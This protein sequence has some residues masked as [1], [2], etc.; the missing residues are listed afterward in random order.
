MT[1]PCHWFSE[2]VGL[3]GLTA[4][5]SSD[6][7]LATWM[8]FG[9]N[10]HDLGSFGEETDKITDLHQIHEK[11]FFIERRDGIASIKRCRRDLSSDGVR[12]L[13]TASGRGRLKE[14]LESS[15]FPA[16]VYEDALAFDHEISS[17]PIVHMVHALDFTT[18]TEE[19]REAIRDRLRM[20]HTDAQ[21]HIVF[22]RGLRCRMY[23]RQFIL[24]MG[25]H[26]ADEMDSVGFRVYWA[27]SVRK[28]ADK[29]D[30]SAHWIE[31]SSD[32]DFLSTFPS[33]TSIRDPLRRLCHKL[34]AFSIAGRSQ[35][36]K[37]V[38]STD[39]FCLRSMDVGA[40]NVP[41]LLAQYLLRYASERKRGARMSIGQFV[42]HLAAH[43]R[44]LTDERL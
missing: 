31:I 43:F 8:T 28:I 19:M 32:G 7:Q 39:F 21:G 34:I 3:A 22:T 12:D 36:P 16:I 6:Y 1:Y 23:W 4:L 25:L 2:Q 30:L 40:A 13:A 14:D 5:L 35:A 29:G 38:T 20:E 18:L 26:T 37:K 9:G 17:K 15:T 11:V 44:L 27:K 33:Y 42:S 10:T 41:Y 24:A